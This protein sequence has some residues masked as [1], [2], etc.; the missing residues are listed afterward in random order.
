MG[1]EFFGIELTTTGWVLFFTCG[2]LIGLAKTGLSGAGLLVV[3]VMAHVFGGRPSV[4]IVLPML[5][6]A[7]VYAVW[8]Y[9][10][11]ADW[12]HIYKLLP[13]ALAGI[14]VGLITGK[15]INDNQFKQ[16]IAIL[17]IAGIVL[18][19]WQDLRKKKESVPSYWWFSAILGLTGGFATMVGNAAG[20][21]MAIYLLSMR[22]PKNRYIGTGAWFFFILNMTKVPLHVFFWKTIHW[23]SLSLNL[24]GLPAILFGA[25][26]GVFLVTLFPEKLYRGFIILSTLASS[27]ILFIR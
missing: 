27:I 12:K 3:P 5:I 16:L 21:I 25:V 6:M 2:L 26:T 8:Y 9:N 24:I 19:L 22:L 7:D 20:P 13:W 15:L 14:M 10:R 1:A 18:M 11:H 23:Q 17:V 4:G